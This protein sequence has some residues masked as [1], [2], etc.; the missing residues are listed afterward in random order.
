MLL[1]IHAKNQ[2]IKCI[3]LSS[4]TTTFHSKTWGQ[5]FRLSHFEAFMQLKLRAQ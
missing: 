4:F 5:D 3:S 1:P 2:K